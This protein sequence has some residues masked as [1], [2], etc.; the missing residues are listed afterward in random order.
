MPDAPNLSCGDPTKQALMQR[1]IWSLDMS[2]LNCKTQAN[3]S[4]PTQQLTSDPAYR[5]EY[6]Q[7]SADGS[8]ILFVRMDAQDNASLW[9]MNADGSDQRELVD[10]FDIP[11]AADATTPWFG[12]YGTISWHQSLA[13]W[14]P[15][16]P[17]TNGAPTPD[18]SPEHNT[19]S[20]PSLGLTVQYP[21]GWD[22]G[23]APMP[24]ASCVSCSVLGPASAEHP[25][26]V[27]IF[28]MPV[29]YDALGCCSYGYVGNNTIGIDGGP[30]G[31][32]PGSTR[33]VRVAGI[34]AQQ[35]EFRRN[36]AL[37]LAAE[38]G[39]YT[40]YREIWTALPWNGGTLFITAFFRDGDTAAEQETRAAYDLALTTL[41]ATP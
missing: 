5:D 13:W 17:P 15:R 6:P 24:Y 35:V 29:N 41:A 4:P 31:G 39:D 28:D 25:Y 38:T 10:R 26:G 19:L 32:S 8:Q 23:A 18:T 2:Q 22:G 9:I 36:A 7:W 16:T 27:E 21:P 20:I 37:G 14:R 11:A 40:P 3:C 33:M 34:D 12:Y 30:V 1:K